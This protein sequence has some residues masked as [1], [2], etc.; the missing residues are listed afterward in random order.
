[1][2]KSKKCVNYHKSRDITTFGDKFRH[3]FFVKRHT[4]ANIFFV[5]VF[6][7]YIFINI[8]AFKIS[9][10]KKMIKNTF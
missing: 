3:V 9:K 8:F 1:M 7:L 10:N 2:T 4:G 5:Q 6:F